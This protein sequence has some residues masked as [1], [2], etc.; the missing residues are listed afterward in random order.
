[1]LIAFHI[2][3]AMLITLQMPSSSSF[4]YDLMIYYRHFLLRYF[5]DF[6]LRFR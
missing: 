3:A 2:A 4:R 5:H 1:M 6:S